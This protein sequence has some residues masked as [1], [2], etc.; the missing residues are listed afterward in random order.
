MENVK[1]EIRNFKDNIEDFFKSLTKSICLFV[2]IDSK[3]AHNVLYWILIEAVNMNNVFKIYAKTK[4]KMGQDL[5]ENSKTITHAINL[6]KEHNIIIPSQK[7]NKYTYF[8][9][10]NIF[11]RNSFLNITKLKL[12]KK[13]NHDFKKGEM[14]IEKI[15][16][17]Y[18]KN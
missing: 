18:Y 7:E 4:R 1:Y 14:S 5:K 16:T 11:A 13:F 12:E 2:G 17:I 10:P 3:V 9:N 8:L 6:L 15:L